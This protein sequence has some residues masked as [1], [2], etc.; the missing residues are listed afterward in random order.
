MTISCCLQ[1]RFRVVDQFKDFLAKDLSRVRTFF[2]LPTLF[3]P[4][5]RP[6]KDG[7]FLTL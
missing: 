6:Q 5:I 2:L 7:V 1:D 4:N 3:I